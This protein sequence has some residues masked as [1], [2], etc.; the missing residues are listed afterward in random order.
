[1]LFNIL[2]FLLIWNITALALDE[3]LFIES[4]KSSADFFS[5]I[6][7]GIKCKD[8]NELMH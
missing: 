3:I 2:A 5:Y 1:M 7:F 8:Y 6:Y 4:F